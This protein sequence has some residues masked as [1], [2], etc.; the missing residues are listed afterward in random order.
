MI[1]G[2]PSRKSDPA[3]LVSRVM[4]GDRS[5]ED[6]LITLFQ[7]SVLLYFRW[8]VGDREASDELA[9]DALMAVIHAVRSGRVQ[10]ASK[11]PGFVRGTA[12]NMANNYL[13]ART[14]RPVEEPL[15]P[16]LAIMD[17]VERIEHREEWTT[18]RRG[19]ERLRHMERQI[20]LMTVVD[21]FKPAQIARYLGLTP[22]VVRA[23]KSRAVRKLF[24]IWRGR[25]P[26]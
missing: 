10:D 6:E 5:A 12:R 19:L 3:A 20:M 26:A 9:N 21:G 11:L 17:L 25:L 23:R 24:E 7:R 22:Q 8:R 15:D 16:E 18:V 14:A 13:R 2:P 4:A 1:G